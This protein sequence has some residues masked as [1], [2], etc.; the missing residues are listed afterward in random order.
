MRI[1]VLLYFY[2]LLFICLKLYTCKKPYQT[3]DGFLDLY[4]GRT[5]FSITQ[6]FES[7]KKIVLIHG[8]RADLTIYFE[9][10]DILVKSGYQVLLYDLLGHGKSE[11]RLKGYFTPEKFANQLHE[12][13]LS[14]DF[15]DDYFNNDNLNGKKVVV[16]GASLGALIALKYTN[17]YHK[18]VKKLIL[19]CPPGLFTK[20]D[21]RNIYKLLNSPFAKFLSDSYKHPN[22]FIR[23]AEALRK[24]GILHKLDPTITKNRKIDDCYHMDTCVVAKIGKHSFF[25]LF[26]EYIN[27]SKL[28]NTVNILFLW[29]MYD[30]VVPFE[31]VI[32]F[33]PKYFN[34]TRIVVFPYVNHIP[35]YPANI[36][37]K[38]SLEFLDK[39]T[40]VGIPLG[41]I[42]NFR[43]FFNSS[44]VINIVEGINYTFCEDKFV[45][46]IDNNTYPED[47]YD[48][49]LIKSS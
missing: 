19:M 48:F 36:P 17:M 14:F 23:G 29:G 47:Y 34:T 1:F 3:L 25:N 20:Q 12:L 5:H 10:R 4:S 40:E 30:L 37:I 21:H 49:P 24:M 9:W 11:W 44:N 31:P 8:L 42:T 45:F 27:L 26:S 38:V 2:L 46:N 32:S 7:K 18:T 33:L 16:L 15:I 43:Y 41:S 13:L 28:E 35:N 6:N 22:T 39:E